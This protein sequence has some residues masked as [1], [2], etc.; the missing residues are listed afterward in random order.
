[1]RF[2]KRA[3]TVSAATLTLAGLTACGA[4][5]TAVDCTTASNEA[6]KI[7]NEWSGSLAKAV[8]DPAAMEKASTEAADKTKALAAKYDG[9][10]ASALNDLASSFDSIKGLQDASKLTEFTTKINGFS[11]KIQSACS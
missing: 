4:V 9:E 8:T 7:M 10:L 11:T 2:L 6:T 1:M 5:G 3:I